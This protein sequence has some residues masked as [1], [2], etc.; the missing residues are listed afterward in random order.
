VFGLAD[1]YFGAGM[2]RGGSLIWGRRN[3]NAT[4]NIAR[5]LLFLIG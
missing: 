4:N 3:K 2:H 1:L 5:S